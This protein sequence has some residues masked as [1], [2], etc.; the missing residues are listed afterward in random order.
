[1]ESNNKKILVVDDEKTIRDFFK[2]L[3]SLSNV[4]VAEAEDGY[5]AIKLARENKFNI[6]FVD[7]RMPGLD[8]LETS[9]RIH[10]INPEA[11]ITIITGYAMSEAVKQ[12]Q[13]EGYRIISKPFDIKDIEDVI[14]N[15]K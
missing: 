10:Q 9:R 15:A 6:F 3:L 13:E 12:A 11:A 8:G 5:T 1:M 2:R 7:M 4:E 14:K